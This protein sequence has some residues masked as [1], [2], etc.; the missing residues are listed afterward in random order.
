[1][2]YES[3]LEGVG[4]DLRNE[5]VKVAPVD[6]G[7][8]RNAIR[9]EIKGDT[10]EIW[11]PEYAIW[12]EYGTG[13]Y[14]PHHQKIV[15]K[16]KKFLHWTDRSGEHFARSTKGMQPQPFIRNTFY[17]KLRDIVNR[18]AELHLDSEMDVEFS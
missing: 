9:Y 10:I 17:H 12:L 7:F 13:L 4:N 8:L 15:P 11:M 3:F 18:N 6:T 1:M 16:N 5:L 2:T 14:G